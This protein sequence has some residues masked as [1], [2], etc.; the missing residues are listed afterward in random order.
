MLRN[1]LLLLLPFSVFA[2]E[3]PFS[4]HLQSGVA[5]HKSVGYYMS[6]EMDITLLKGL[7]L[8]PRF[9]FASMVPNTFISATYSPNTS[10]HGY[11]SDGPRQEEEYGTQVSYA[12]LLLTLKPLEWWG[13]NPKHELRFS[14]GLQYS[15]YTTYRAS[16]D[17][18]GPDPSLTHF[19]MKSY[20]SIV[21]YY[22]NLGYQYYVNDQLG[23]GAEVG[24]DGTD[25]DG[26]AYG[27]LRVGLRL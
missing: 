27:G 20:P 7:A 3:S 2:Q 16:Y 1:V 13:N 26:M 12:A 17:M 18:S 9:G 8:T 5:A 25:G 6:G 4:I 24:L 22:L 14:T 23:I 10:S 15:G 19:H 21:P 11:P